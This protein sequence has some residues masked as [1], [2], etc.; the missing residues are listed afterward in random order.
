[1]RTESEQIIHLKDYA[2]SPYRIVSADLTFDIAP[3]RCSVRSLL[4]IEPTSE[5]APEMPLHLDG[6]DLT[7]DEIAIDGAP[8]MHSAYATASGGLTIM[9]PPQRRFVLETH[10]FVEP[11]KNS[12]L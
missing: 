2:P 3:E 1:M 11:E 6:E 12:A 10:V 9:A 5:T 4:T 8:L 7:L